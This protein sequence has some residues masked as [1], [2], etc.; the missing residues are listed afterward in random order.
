MHNILDVFE[1]WP[2]GTTDFGVQAALEC[3]KN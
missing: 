3:L 1:F 2:D